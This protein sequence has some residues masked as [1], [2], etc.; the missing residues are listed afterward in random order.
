MAGPT[1]TIHPPGSVPRLADN[2]F[3]RLIPSQSVA[4]VSDFTLESGVTLTDVSVG[5]RT[6]GNSTTPRTMSWSSATP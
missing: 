3:S 6:W 4:V 2:R 1:V 5:F